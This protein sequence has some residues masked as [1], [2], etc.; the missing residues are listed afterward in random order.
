MSPKPK[1]RRTDHVRRTGLLSTALPRYYG[2][3]IF[4]GDE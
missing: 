1:V 3:G 4:T 2:K